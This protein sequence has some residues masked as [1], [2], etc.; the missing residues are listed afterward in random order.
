MLPIILRSKKRVLLAPSR[1]L[2]EVD[3]ETCTLCGTCVEVC[4]VEALSMNGKEGGEPLTVNEDLCIG[5][6]QCVYQ[7]PEDAMELKE[8]RNPD[9][10]PGAVA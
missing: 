8:V 7:C 10:I 2:P 9:F 3:E 4:P 1:F 6:G 5:C